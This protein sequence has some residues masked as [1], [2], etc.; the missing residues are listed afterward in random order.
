MVKN[1]VSR[2]ERSTQRSVFRNLFY[3]MI[4]FGALVGI[5]FPPFAKIVLDSER[6]L[7]GGFFA[8]CV[9]AGLVVG[10]VNFTLF[11][12]VVSRDL[13]RVVGAMRAVLEHV[14][15]AED[16]GE[17]SQVECQLA[18]T[19]ND[20]I[21]D[22]ECSFNEM[23]EAIARRLEIEISSRAL[24]TNLAHSVE[25]E[26]VSRTM[27]SNLA[28]I[29]AAKAAL[30]YGNTD[31]SFALLARFGVDQSDMLPTEINR[32][33]GPV[34]LAVDS[35][36]IVSLST[37]RDGLAWLSQSTPLGSFRPRN[38]LAVPLVS[39]Q[40]VVGLA[41]LA[42]AAD[43]L[44]PR[45]MQRLEGL[46]TQAAPYLQNAILHRKITDLAALDDLTKIMNR[47]FGLRRLEE[48]FS[49]AV[50]HGVPLSVLMI[51]VD[52]F[53][54]VNDSF[55]HE[56]GDLVLKMIATVLESR[57]RAEDV[58]CR[59]GGEEFMMVA[60]GIGLTDGVKV[61][62]RL[63][64]TIESSNVPWGDSHI[65][66]TISIGISTWPTCRASAAE[67]LV[68]AADKAL[69]TAKQ[70]GRNQVVVMM[71]DKAVPFCA[72]ETDTAAAPGSS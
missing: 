57:T 29:C 5:L 17:G 3:S 47:R 32:G 16:A 11:R 33:Q 44:T 35:G 62:E 31:A 67:E 22:I 39:R 15:T 61:A 10:V 36:A 14:T 54:L 34:G 58:V 65:Q 20:A 24:N 66:V 12:I 51:D 23:T 43:E 48:E 42:C 37:E 41:I 68:S 6:A 59:F 55:G 27:L 64:R 52:H 8:M 56:A 63:R 72:L 38:V 28:E 9:M 49:R 30:L 18:V 53:K 70:T 1:T 13:A 19:S 25:L 69:Y 7:S 46:R 4:A 71:P 45:Q 26:D 60:L 2:P 50:R 21:G 40:Q